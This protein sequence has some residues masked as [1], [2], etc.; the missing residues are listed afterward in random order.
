[1]PGTISGRAVLPGVCQ[2][3]DAC[4][5]RWQ[6]T[7]PLPLAT[8]L[9]QARPCCGTPRPPHACSWPRPT[10][11]RPT[12]RIM[13]S[14][15]CVGT[16]LSRLQAWDMVPRAARSAAA[17]RHA[18]RRAGCSS[19]R[20]LTSHDTLPAH[21]QLHYLPADAARAD[22]V[23]AVPL[24]K[25]GPVH[26]VKWSPEGD[27]FCVVA[28]YMPAKVWPTR[29][30]HSLTAGRELAAAAAVAAAGTATAEAAGA[31]LNALH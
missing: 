18:Q 27:F 21:A 5:R 6:R 20:R 29:A 19:T 9:C 8:S 7:R 3:A 26:D 23:T 12:S 15:R 11:T 28:G 22:T 30:R 25:D 2:P 16:S 10:P 14:P 1:M 17:E 31:Q 13:G 24:P 4:L